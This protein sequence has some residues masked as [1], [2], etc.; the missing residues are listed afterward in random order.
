[1]AVTAREAEYPFGFCQ[2]Y[3]QVV[4]RALSAWYKAE[5]PAELSASSEWV[6]EALDSSAKRFQRGEVQLQLHVAPQVL[7]MLRG[8]VQCREA[9]HLVELFRLADYRGSDVRLCSA[10]LV[11]GCHQEAP[12]PSPAW[13]WETVQAYKW[14]VSHH[15]KVLELTAF[16]NYMRS[17]AGSVDF[18]GKRIFNIFDSCDAACVVA[19]G[20]SSSK[21][22][23][24]VCR[25]VMAL[26]LATNTYLR[27]HPVDHQQVAILLCSQ[28]AALTPCLECPCA[29]RSSEVT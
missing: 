1:M 14:E 21:V 18:H 15:I 2:A 16:L 11:D 10:E 29:S 7:R 17:Q 28:P 3:A 19:K 24:C 23:N 26:S 13:K 22:L 12:Y 8:M 9:E 25:R 27:D 5:L 4:R 6:Q 20:S